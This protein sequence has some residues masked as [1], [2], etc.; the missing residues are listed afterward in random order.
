MFPCSFRAAF[1]YRPQH[2]PVGICR[3]Q[4]ARQHGQCSPRDESQP[5]EAEMTPTCGTISLVASLVTI[6]ELKHRESERR[7]QEI[8]EKLRAAFN[9]A[10]IE[11][12]R[13]LAQQCTV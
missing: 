10:L 13:W 2:P 9:E 8:G 5:L 1:L 7:L 12:A 4:Q 3:W 11:D 6:R